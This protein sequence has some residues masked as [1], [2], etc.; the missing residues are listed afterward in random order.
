MLH[1]CDLS[2]QKLSLLAHLVFRETPFW[3]IEATA[4]LLCCAL[5]TLDLQYN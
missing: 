4:V 3:N 5:V 1:I 2:L